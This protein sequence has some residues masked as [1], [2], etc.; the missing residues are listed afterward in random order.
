[1]G[2]K[3]QFWFRNPIY[4]LKFGVKENYK[5][6]Y[7]I[8]IFYTFSCLICPRRL[9]VQITITNK[10]KEK[11]KISAPFT[12]PPQKKMLAKMC[13]QDFNN[14]WI[15]FHFLNILFMMSLLR[16]PL[17]I[18]KLSQRLK[19]LVWDFSFLTCSIAS[20]DCSLQSLIWAWFNS[21]L[22]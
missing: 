21:S 10:I 15:H 4:W 3:V 7:I 11:N 12:P 22:K 17:L 19:S 20:K 16:L 8:Y 1:M 9:K 2:I 18:C 14:L 6:Q 5:I 13:F